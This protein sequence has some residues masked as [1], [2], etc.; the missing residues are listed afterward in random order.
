MR[1]PTSLPLRQAFFLSG[2][3]ATARA[4]SGGRESGRLAYISD[5][6][7]AARL[8]LALVFG[9]LIGLERESYGRPAGFRTH[10]L[11]CLGAALIMI[12]SVF[13]IAAVRF[14]FGR[15]TYDAARIAA[16]VVSGIG[17]LG[18]GTI[19]R[20]GSTVRGLTTAASL[21]VV[22]GIGMAVGIGAYVPALITTGLVLITLLFL[23]NVE[24]YFLSTKRHVLFI[25]ISDEPGQLGAIGLVL[26][27][28]GVNI[29]NV[30]MDQDVHP[31][32]LEL[33]L[34]LPKKLDRIGMLE[35]ISQIDGVISVR[36]RD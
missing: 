17:F 29:H 20:E 24:R 7:I 14:P 22:A 30:T 32:M 19:M 35:E 23:S 16:Q 5:W 2:T 33:S 25:E 28:H 26:G 9:G 15:P 21:W 36:S 31:T 3:P 27:R 34:V 1:D 13:G 6:E 12:V 11:V 8:L 10:I 18:A 4:V